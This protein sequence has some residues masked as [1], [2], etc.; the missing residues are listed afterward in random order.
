MAR[1]LKYK[2]Y[3]KIII[4]MT[5]RQNKIN[6]IIEK[7]TTIFF[8]FPFCTFCLTP[9]FV[10]CGGDTTTMLS[11]VGYMVLVLIGW[12]FISFFIKLFNKII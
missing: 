3:I 11:I 4:V 8:V 1:S 10:L 9:M 7:V 12:L 2:E 5:D 6:S